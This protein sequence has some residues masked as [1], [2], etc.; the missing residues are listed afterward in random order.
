MTTAANIDMAA[1]TRHAVYR[2]LLFLLPA[3]SIGQTERFAANLALCR[4]AFNA[5]GDDQRRRDAV[6]G[7]VIARFMDL[8]VTPDIGGEPWQG[9]QRDLEI[10]LGRKFGDRLADV[11]GFYRRGEAGRWRLNLPEN[12][13]V[14]GYRSA[15]GFYAGVLFQPLDSIDKYFLLSSGRFGGPKAAR[16]LP[17]DQQYFTQFDEAAEMPWPAPPPYVL[18]AIEKA[19][20]K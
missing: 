1:A 5:A 11:P 20:S 10:Y 2:D 13:A 16:M 4:L 7:S 14:Y 9:S 18:A 19:F 15:I 12:A 3:A 6:I 17:A 8:R